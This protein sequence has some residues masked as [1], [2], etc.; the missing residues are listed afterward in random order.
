MQKQRKPEWLG[1]YRASPYVKKKLVE[2]NSNVD[3][4]EW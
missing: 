1:D 2:Y 3:F 4:L